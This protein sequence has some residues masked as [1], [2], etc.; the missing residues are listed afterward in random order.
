MVIPSRM[1]HR[2]RAS[3]RV[4]TTLLPSGGKSAHDGMGGLY[5]FPEGLY[6]PMPLNGIAGLPFNSV[7]TDL[8]AAFITVGIDMISKF[9]LV[10]T[11]QAKI[12]PSILSP[13]GPS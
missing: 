12:H 3:S 2:R 8:P 1:P 4:A 5:L 6:F 11:L 9:R 10:I 7:G 13:E